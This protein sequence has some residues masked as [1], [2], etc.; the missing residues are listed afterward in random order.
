MELQSEENVILQVE[1]KVAF[2]TLNRPKAYNAMNLDMITQI[3]QALKDVKETGTDILIINGNGKGFSAGGDI[4]TMIEDLDEANF[5]PVMDK[6]NEMMVTLYTMPKLVISAVHGAAA[7]LGLSFALAGDYVIVEE[8]SALAMNFI[9]IGLI[10]DGGSHFFLRNLL[11]EAKAKQLIWEG[12]NLTAK[13]A[14][15]LGLIHE[16]VS[17]EAL[18]AA[19]EKAETWLQQPLQSMLETKKVFT[20]AQLPQLLQ[21]LD[22][23]KEGQARMRK[24][25]DHLEGIRA[26]VEKRKP[27]FIGE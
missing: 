6:I 24:T 23:E 17:G 27:N 16:V 26:F 25:R 12:R 5:L 14:F 13:E 18:T 4:R 1:E 15:Q 20:N 7:G 9:Q 21:I 10:P 2:L 19:K 3:L 11:G 8:S 22:L